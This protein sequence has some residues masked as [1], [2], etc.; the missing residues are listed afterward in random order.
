M[1]EFMNNFLLTFNSSVKL[2]VC[3]RELTDL[4]FSALSP[5]ATQSC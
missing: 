5:A 4:N 3:P 1:E 2:R